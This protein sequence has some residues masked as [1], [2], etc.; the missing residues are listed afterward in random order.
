MYQIADDCVDLVVRQDHGEFHALDLD[1]P[2]VEFGIATR[3]LFISGSGFN[4]RECAAAQ[5][6]QGREQTK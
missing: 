2:V 4:P 5:Q 3:S 6:Q 1:G